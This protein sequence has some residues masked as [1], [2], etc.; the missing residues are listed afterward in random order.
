MDIA[1]IINHPWFFDVFNWGIIGIMFLVVIIAVW[2]DKQ[3]RPRP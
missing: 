1:N 2:R 3:K